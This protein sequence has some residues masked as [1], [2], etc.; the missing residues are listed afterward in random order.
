MSTVDDVLARARSAVG[1]STL[2]WLGQGGQDPERA[3]PSSPLPAGKLWPTLPASQRAELEPLAQ[4]LGIDV[5][6]PRLV[7]DACDCS[8]YVCWVLGFARHTTP[9]SFT[10]PGGWIFT[11]SIWADAM[12]PGHRF[13]RLDTARPGA[14]VVYPRKGSGKQYGHVGIVMEADASG[15]A[16]QVA[17]CSADNAKS[18]LFDAIQITSA[19]VFEQN[20]H[21]LYAWCQTVR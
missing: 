16:T 19:E 8:G 15:R 6:D 10:D 5:H 12:G 21:S 20:V 9:A 13:K 7:L 11:D 18:E 2:Y 3:R 1:H 4:K 17:H 14:L